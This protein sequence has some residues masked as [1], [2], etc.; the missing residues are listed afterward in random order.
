MHNNEKDHVR[1]QILDAASAVFAKYGYKKATMDDI[2]HAIKKGKTAV[3][4]YFNGKE[5]IF[6]A[7]VEREAA[8]LGKSIVSA[9]EKGKTASEKFALY[10]HA[11][12]NT[13]QK[14]SNFYDAMKNELLDSLEFINQARQTYDSF[15]ISMVND[16]LKAGNKE[17]AFNVAKTE[18]TAELIVAIL[19]GLEIHLFVVSDPS[20][21][22][23]K[24]GEIIF[25]L[26][27]GL[28]NSSAKK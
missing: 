8:M 27:N 3:Y 23:Q 28:S 21:L 17:G 12:V 16:I 1:E 26:T 11:R 10:I 7:I 14:V 22:Q 24:T 25:L 2:G 4:Y 18:S 15:E 6:R 5:D 19:K 13:L 9:I 20:K